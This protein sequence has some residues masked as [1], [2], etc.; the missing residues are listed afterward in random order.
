MQSGKIP[1]L[2]WPP[3]RVLQAAVLGAYLPRWHN[4]PHTKT[5][6]HTAHKKRQNR[7]F[8]TIRAYHIQQGDKYKCDTS[9]LRLYCS[10]A[11]YLYRHPLWHNQP[12]RWRFKIFFSENF[13]V[14]FLF[15]FLRQVTLS[16]ICRYYQFICRTIARNTFYVQLVVRSNFNRLQRK[17]ECLCV[18]QEM[19]VIYHCLGI[20]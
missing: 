1:S 9:V 12:L 2:F 11:C 15:S 8:A 7:R 5:K 6:A 10:L 3:R 13:Y 18:L 17:Y 16:P 4:T 14:I 19:V 20:K